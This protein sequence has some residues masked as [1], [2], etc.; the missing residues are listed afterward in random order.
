MVQEG[1]GYL[2]A[3]VRENAQDNPYGKESLGS[4]GKLRQGGVGK[5]CPLPSFAAATA[6]QAF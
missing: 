3:E 6:H 1:Y 5:P 2:M 4:N